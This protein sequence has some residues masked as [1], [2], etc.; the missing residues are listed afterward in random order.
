MI[1]DQEAYDKACAKRQ[2]AH[3][4]KVAIAAIHLP[5]IIATKHEGIIRASD[6]DELRDTLIKDGVLGARWNARHIANAKKY[7]KPLNQWE[8]QT[9]VSVVDGALTKAEEEGKI[10][11]SSGLSKSALIVRYNEEYSPDAVSSANMGP[12]DPDE[13][14]PLSENLPRHRAEYWNL[15]YAH[16]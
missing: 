9:A 5:R 14:Y 13:L 2:R 16:E 6:R 15:R 3:D 12:H 4:A 10:S 11:I 1:R 8:L 7:G